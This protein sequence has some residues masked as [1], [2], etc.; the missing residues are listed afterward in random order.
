MRELALSE[1]GTTLQQAAAAPKA[2]VSIYGPGRRNSLRVKIRPSQA[3]GRR[4]YTRGRSGYIIKDA[5]KL[6]MNGKEEVK[7]V[8]F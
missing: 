4:I 7:Y 6:E 1:S 8:I 3:A 2:E 5:S